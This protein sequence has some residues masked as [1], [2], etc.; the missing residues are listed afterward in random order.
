MTENA[1]ANS[2]TVEKDRQARPGHAADVRR[3]TIVVPRGTM[4]WFARRV[5]FKIGWTLC[6]IVFVLF[7]RYRAYGGKNLGS[8]KEGGVIVASNHQS[9]FDPVIIGLGM[10]NR[11]CYALARATLF[12]NPLL[13][14]IIRWFNAIPVDRGEADRQAIKDCVE[15]LESGRALMLFPEGTR[16]RDGSVGR[17]K[18]GLML[19][20]RKAKVPVVPI[21]IA[22]SF[23][24]WPRDRK[25]PRLFGKV[26]VK[27]GEP[28]SPETLADMKR[29]DAMKLVED[30]VKELHEQ[31]CA[32]RGHHS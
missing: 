22:G 20:Q 19:I 2:D 3:G 17:F 25:F 12:K 8:V 29:E 24:A 10:F 14:F 23:A 26:A 6:A 7:Y 31:L 13:G 30:R 21:A 5:Y 28:I 15:V 9:H 11:E 18:P 1:Q 16:T 4:L 27:F 32:H